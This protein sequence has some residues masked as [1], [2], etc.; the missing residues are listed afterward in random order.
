MTPESS[1]TDPVEIE[2]VR[3]VSILEH[4]GDL[5]VDMQI[6]EPFCPDADG[7]GMLMVPHG[8]DVDIFVDAPDAMPPPPMLNRVPVP[9]GRR[10]GL[11][12][13]PEGS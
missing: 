9:V 13:L 3:P 2:G 4:S 10:S 7:T 5:I 6:Y 1:W 12:R 8:D 11:Q